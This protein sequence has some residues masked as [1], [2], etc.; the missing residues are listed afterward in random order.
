MRA[1]G[2]QNQS[3]GGEKAAMRSS[4]SYKRGYK[5]RR[6]QMCGHRPASV[7]W[8]RIM[9]VVRRERSAIWRSDNF[10]LAL[11]P[12]RHAR[13]ESSLPSR[14]MRDSRDC[15][16]YIVDPTWPVGRSICSVQRRASRASDARALLL[17]LLDYFLHD[18]HSQCSQLVILAV[19]D[20]LS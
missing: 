20:G 14:K 11:S 7:C 15:S 10:P 2:V 1:A 16:S 6:A 19:A 17:P 5:A 12:T 8:V 3:V 9:E 18:C 13:L 4:N